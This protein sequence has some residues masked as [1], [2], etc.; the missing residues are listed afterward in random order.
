[1][2]GDGSRKLL[3]ALH[4]DHAWKNLVRKY[5]PSCNQGLPECVYQRFLRLL[6]ATDMENFDDLLHMFVEL[7][8]TSEK[9]SGFGHHF[10]NTYGNSVDQ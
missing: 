4:T 5:L 1:M 9:M 7:M 3:C 6:D 10:M 8:S 2:F